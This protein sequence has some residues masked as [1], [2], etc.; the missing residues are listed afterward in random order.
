MA[1][2]AKILAYGAVTQED[3]E[4]FQQL[5]QRNAYNMNFKSY[6]IQFAAE[7]E[8]QDLVMQEVRKWERS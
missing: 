1:K 4:I 2:K 5:V 3:K 8:L 6:E 7:K